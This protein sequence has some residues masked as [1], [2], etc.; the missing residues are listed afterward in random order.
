MSC[1]TDVSA[2]D[3]TLLSGFRLHLNGVP[4]QPRPA[5]QRLLAFLALH[6]PGMSRGE[7]ATAL[8]VGASEPR[9]LANLRSTLWRLPRRDDLSLVESSATHV[10]LDPTVRVDLHDRER[11]AEGLL[12]DRRSLTRLPDPAELSHDVLPGWHDGWLAPEQERFRQLRLHALEALC[13][14]LTAA[15]RFADALDAGLLVVVAEPLRES[16]HRRVIETHLAEGNTAE[17]HRQ[18][19]LCRQ[20]LQQQLGVEPSAAMRRLVTGVGRRRPA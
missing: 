13:A 16:A 2:A 14:R 10:R 17:A 18:F 11:Q 19:L 7:T 3:L 15:G 5:A 1:S 9:A 8:W 6:R 20:L 12:S 4:L